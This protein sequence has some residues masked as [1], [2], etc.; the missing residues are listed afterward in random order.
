MDLPKQWSLLLR[1]RKLLRSLHVHGQE[2]GPW[3]SRDL[4]L[5]C[6]TKSSQEGTIVDTYQTIQLVAM[7]RYWNVILVV[8]AVIQTDQNLAEARIAAKHRQT[9]S[10]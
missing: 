7:K 2:L 4:H 3:L 10:P 9:D 5:R 8:T 6:V 1:C